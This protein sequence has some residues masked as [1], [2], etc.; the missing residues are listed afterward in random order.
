MSPASG[1][2]PDRPILVLVVV[3]VVVVE[4]DGFFL[5]RGFEDDG[6][7][8]DNDDDSRATAPLMKYLKPINLLDERPYRPERLAVYDALYD[9]FVTAGL[10]APPPVADYGAWRHPAYM[11]PRGYMVPYLSVKWYVEHAREAKRRRVNAQ[12]VLAAFRDEPWR[13]KDMLGD[14]YD[15]LLVDQPL[16]DPAEEEHFGLASTPGSALVGVGAV[17]STSGIDRLER[18]AYSLLKTLAMRVAAHLFGVPAL[19]S[20]C[21][22]MAPRVACENPCLLGPCLRMPEDLERLTDLRLAGP[23]LCDLCVADLRANLIRSDE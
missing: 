20:E 15:F 23:P 16:F 6:D 9:L 14:H 22:A 10:D 5:A 2:C 18:V 4:S 12:A 13:H 19:R 8:G 7:D 17:L 1:R 11:D 3:I 21:L